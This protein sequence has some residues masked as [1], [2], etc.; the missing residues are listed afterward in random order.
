MKHKNKELKK[1]KK[2]KESD[3][4]W[5]HFII[6]AFCGYDFMHTKTMLISKTTK[7][8]DLLKK[9]SSNRPT[10]YKRV[11]N[12]SYRKGTPC[13]YPDRPHPDR[14][15]NRKGRLCPFFLWAKVDDLG[16][17]AMLEAWERVNPIR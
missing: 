6:E 5:T 16:Y 4:F 15:L 8:D 11:K 10:K 9:L 7:V 12:T 13:K 2:K 14:C 1:G 3:G 17:R